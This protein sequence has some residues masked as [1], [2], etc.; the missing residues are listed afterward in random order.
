MSHISGS[1]KSKIRVPVWLRSGEG[2]PPGL[3]LSFFFFFLIAFL[4]YPHMEERERETELVL[5]SLYNLITRIP[6]LWSHLNL[7]TSKISTSK[8]HRIGSYGFIMNFNGPQI[9]SL[10]TLP[11]CTHSGT[12][13]ES[14]LDN[15]AQKGRR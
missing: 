2:S 7:S 6:P 1:W 13:T 4:L 11:Y 3:E 15:P 9:F 14:T 12:D 8:C 10:Y 5:W